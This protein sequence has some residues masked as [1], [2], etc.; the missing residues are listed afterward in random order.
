MVTEQMGMREEWRFVS[1]DSGGQCVM[2]HG[3]TMM[4]KLCAGNLVLEQQVSCMF[5]H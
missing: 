3:I 4:L 1:E 2:T 5:M